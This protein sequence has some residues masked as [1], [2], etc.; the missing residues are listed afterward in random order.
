[1]SAAKMATILSRWRWVNS[2]Y[3]LPSN[4]LWRQEYWWETLVQVYNWTLWNLSEIILKIKSSSLKKNAFQN[5]ACEMAAIL[6]RHPRANGES[7][8][9][10]PDEER[11]TPNQWAHDEI[12]T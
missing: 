1:M 3:I 6:F 7:P 5:V 10:Q 4:S 12:I 8:G 9:D 2:F 11:F